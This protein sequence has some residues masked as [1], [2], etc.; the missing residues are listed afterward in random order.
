MMVDL[1]YFVSENLCKRADP[2]RTTI[3]FWQ[4]IYLCCGFDQPSQSL[5]LAKH[6]SNRYSLHC[7]VMSRVKVASCCMQLLYRILATNAVDLDEVRLGPQ[8]I[9]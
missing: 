1:E 7:Q 6:S 3:A 8:K 2:L 5:M 4:C 9:E